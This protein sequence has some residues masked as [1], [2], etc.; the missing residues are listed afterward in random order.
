MAAR[1]AIRV[2]LAKHVMKMLSYSWGYVNGEVVAGRGVIGA[3]HL[4]RQERSTEQSCC[5]D[6]G[7]ESFISWL[8]FRQ[9]PQQMKKKKHLY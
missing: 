2:A 1:A 5:K 9:S 8:Y 4:A 6:C 7:S 3:I